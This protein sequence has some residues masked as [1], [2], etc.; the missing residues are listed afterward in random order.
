MIPAGPFRIQGRPGLEGEGAYNSG[1]NTRL[2]PG[3]DPSQPSTACSRPTDP[4]SGGSDRRRGRLWAAVLIALV[5]DALQIGLLPLFMEGAAVP[6]NDALDV[7]V[8]LTLIAL[9][10]WHV[11]FLPAFASELVPFLNLLPTWTA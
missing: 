10:G 3:S 5:A 2:S 11:A 4:S 8:G 1:V 7:G 9:L 6:W